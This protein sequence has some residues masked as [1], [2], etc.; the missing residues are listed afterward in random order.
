MKQKIIR[1]IVGVIA[2]EILSIIAVIALPYEYGKTI[3]T[4]AN[5]GITL[6]IVCAAIRFFLPY[7][8]RGITY[9]VNHRKD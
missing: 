8:K 2:L 9:I 4:I 1:I 5:N 6:I 7:I 3:N